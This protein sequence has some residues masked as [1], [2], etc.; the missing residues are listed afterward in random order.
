MIVYTIQSRKVVLVCNPRLYSSINPMESMRLLPRI[1]F[2]FFL[3]TNYNVII[4]NVMNN[5][6]IR[7]RMFVMTKSNSSYREYSK[8][9]LIFIFRLLFKKL[10][11]WIFTFFNL[12]RFYKN[13]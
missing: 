1:F 6:K 9:L 11:M 10:V 5:N 4:C 8:Y 13:I 3:M 7:S 2:Y 12:A